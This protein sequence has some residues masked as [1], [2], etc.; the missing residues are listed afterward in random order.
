M[1]SLIVSFNN[2]R[3]YNTV[4]FDIIVGEP[5]ALDLT[6]DTEGEATRWFVEN[7]PVLDVKVTGLHA[8]C[9]ALEEGQSEIRIFGANGN[10]I[11][12]INIEV[13]ASIAP[14]AAKLEAKVGTA[15]PK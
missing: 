9:Q 4:K 13:V 12:T 2:A 6:P 7:D 14:M 3:A 8:D 15:V 11:M 5:F 1:A 10:L